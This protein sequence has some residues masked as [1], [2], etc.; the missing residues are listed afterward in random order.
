M[1]F[2]Y[3]YDSYPNIDVNCS[4][5][6]TCSVGT[7][8]FWSFGTLAAGAT[9]TLSLGSTVVPTAVGNGNLIR[10]SF[11]ATGTDVSEVHLVKT[12]QVHDSPGAQLALS[13][14][15][16]PVTNAQAFTYNIDVGQIGTSALANTEI[17]ARVPAGLTVGTISDGGVK[18]ASGDIVW[19][20]GTVGVSAYLRRTVAVTGDGTSPP[21]TILAARA[22]ITFDGGPPV[23]AQ[24]EY[25]IPVVSAASP[26][27]LAVSSTPVPVAPGSRLLY[28]ATIT[29]TSARS[30]DGVNIFIRVPIGLQFHYINDVSPRITVNC[31]GSATCAVG[32]EAG[33]TIGSMAAG[34]SQIITVNALVLT[35][36]LDGSLIP[37]PFYLY[38]TGQTSPVLLDNVVPAHR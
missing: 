34:A 11:V 13:A 3:Q 4:G 26:L 33:W 8:A 2:N 19:S 14:T 31:S 22:Q 25:A 32:D 7:E 38:S 10:S 20:V 37:A 15:A 16:N 35:T 24:A 21:G 17:R 30:I 27:T 12:I 23:D 1:Q 29:N 28:T 36:L 6:A 18:D 5:S 9:T